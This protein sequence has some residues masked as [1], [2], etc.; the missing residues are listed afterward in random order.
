LLAFFNVKFFTTSSV[1][2]I[3]II[4]IGRHTIQF[5][6]NPETMYATKETAAAVMAYG[7]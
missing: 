3:R 7:S 5:L 1:T 2:S 6:T 4:P